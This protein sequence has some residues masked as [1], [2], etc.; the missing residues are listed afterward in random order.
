MSIVAI[1]CEGEL[2][3]KHFGYCS[4][5]NLYSIKDGKIIKKEKVDNPGHKPG[6][7]PVFLHDL[8]VTVL[9]TGGIGS[10]A[11]NIFNEK[12]IKVYSGATGSSDKTV[13][14]FIKGTLESTGSICRE[15]NH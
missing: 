2:I 5:F 9:I 11:V 6:F 3:S 15:H 14:H 1:A 8:E 13:E 4:N 10:S 7:L 12:G